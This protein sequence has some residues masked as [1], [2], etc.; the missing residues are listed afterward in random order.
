MYAAHVASAGGIE[1]AA[2][3]AAAASPARSVR[4]AVTMCGNAAA[5]EWLC[6]LNVASMPCR[7]NPATFQAMKRHLVAEPTAVLGSCA[8]CL[9]G[10]FDTYRC[11]HYNSVKT[12]FEQRDSAAGM[13]QL[14]RRQRQPQLL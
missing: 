3:L 8:G 5:I 12:H 10:I 2:H 14:R 7:E 13:S 11:W 9:A 1:K 4:V 6:L